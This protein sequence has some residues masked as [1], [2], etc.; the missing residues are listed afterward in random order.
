MVSDN[1]QNAIIFLRTVPEERFYLALNGEAWRLLV[2]WIRSI[3]FV[4]DFKDLGS[5]Q[6][7]YNEDHEFYGYRMPI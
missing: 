6:G 7:G 5:G 3:E 4:E 2:K 1:F